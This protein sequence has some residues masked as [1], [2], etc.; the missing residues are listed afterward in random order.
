MHIHQCSL[1]VLAI[2]A[3][4]QLH[5][6]VEQDAHFD[7]LFLCE[8]VQSKTATCNNNQQD[9]CGTIVKWN[10]RNIKRLYSFA[11]E[12]RIQAPVVVSGW[13]LQE[14]FGAKPKEKRKVIKVA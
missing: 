6:L 13:P 4:R 5:L 9:R 1:A 2:D 10:S 12:Y 14:H 3:E 11:F 7:S 8:T